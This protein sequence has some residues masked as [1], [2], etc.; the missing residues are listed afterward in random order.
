MDI[1]SV[2]LIV[3]GALAIAVIWLFGTRTMTEQQRRHVDLTERTERT[4]RTLSEVRDQLAELNRRTAEV[5]RILKDA[6]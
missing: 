1:A 6:E 2:F 5:E 4:E 3:A